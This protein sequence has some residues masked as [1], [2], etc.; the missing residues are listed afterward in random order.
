METLE[1]RRL[2]A[3]FSVT[4]LADSG[5]GSLRNAIGLA[6]T[7]G[8]P[9]EIMFDI[10]VI[11]TIT[12]NAGPLLITDDLIIDGPGA[13]A[14]T[15]DAAGNSRV[16]EI[17]DGDL[18]NRDVEIRGLTVTG[19]TDVNAFPGGRGG[20][21]YSLEN[22]TV[23]D[24]TLTG[25]QANFGGGIYVHR[26]ASLT[27]NNSFIAGNLAGDGGGIHAIGEL[28]ITSS[29]ITGNLAERGVLVGDGIGGGIY[30]AGTTDINRTSINA[31]T[32]YYGGGIFSGA[33]PNYSSLA[34][35]IIDSTIS[36]NQASISGGGIRS[37]D[38]TLNLTNSTFSG[39][40]S[41]IGGGVHWLHES[42]A[43]SAGLHVR[44]STITQNVASFGGSGVL[45]NPS[46][47]PFYSLMSVSSTIISG[48]AMDDV[49]RAGNG[50]IPF[51]SLG[52]NLI[53][54]G[55]ASTDFS[56][57]SD[58]VGVGDPRLGPLA[59]NGGPTQTHPP[60]LVSPAANRGNPAFVVRPDFDQRG[61][62]FDRVRLGVVDIGAVELQE[63]PAMLVVDT[64][65]DES[66]G[67][68]SPGDLS[69]RE[70]IEI[71]SF[72]G[73]ETVG[74]DPSLAAQTITLALGQFNISAPI[75]IV[76]PIGG[77][78][79]DAAG[80]SRIFN[81]DDE[82][83]GNHINVS[84][85]GFTLSGG[86]VVGVGG[87]IRSLE[88]L[89][90]SNVVVTGNTAT[91][92]GGGIYARHTDFYGTAHITGTTITG[93]RTTGNL[94]SGGGLYFRSAGVFSSISSS[95]FAGNM[96]AGSSAD[97]AGLSIHA[98]G[99]TVVISTST[100][101]GN[102]ATGSDGGGLYLARPVTARS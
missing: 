67:D 95:T 36:G 86:N 85:D 100:I 9:D 93:N 13:S 14:L 68:L 74:F 32:A 26:Y 92:A 98:E 69:L 58:Q 51:D 57:S 44:Y 24:S 20:G 83:N 30:A 27:V 39:N 10:G 55:N 38:N 29:R 40:T 41:F 15:V 42:L 66:D 31:N 101:S 23:D 12:L 76:A 70:A 60:S 96:T 4:T 90:L 7:T 84:L 71:A 52:F 5:P 64:V 45:A 102:T 8:G 1:D 61:P 22:L 49:S 59:D 88:N 73:I 48:N 11:G 99:A 17:D 62:G 3:V 79:L 46:D 65:T 82:V 97:G 94:G 25:N 77:L 35:S 16:F 78:T 18:T 47:G 6:N 87:A 89:T 43:S 91:G 33:H 37:L 19:G 72:F 2:L 75:A 81:I 80:N 56:A 21:I 63:T 53:G 28:T 54:F 34:L 50:A